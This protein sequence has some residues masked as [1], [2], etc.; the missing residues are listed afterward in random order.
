VRK[1]RLRCL[2]HPLEYRQGCAGRMQWEADRL[3]DEA[4]RR[5]A[6][7]A[8]QAAA[9]AEVAR[10]VRAARDECDRRGGGLSTKGVKGAQE[11]C[12]PEQR[13]ALTGRLSRLS[14]WMSAARAWRE[15]W[16]E[17]GSLRCL[18]ER[19]NTTVAALVAKSLEQ[20]PVE[21]P[22]SR[23]ETGNGEGKEEEER[24]TEGAIG[25]VALDPA[26]AGPRLRRL[27]QVCSA[28]RGPAVSKQSGAEDLAGCLCS[29]AE[30]E[31]KLLLRAEVL[32][33]RSAAA[34]DAQASAS[35]QAQ[36]EAERTR[37][38]A[39]TAAEL[40]AKS[41]VFEYLRS[42]GKL[43]DVLRD[44]MAGTHGEGTAAAA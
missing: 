29:E 43:D 11:V 39:A 28:L 26:V 34:R 1:E 37:A 38:A 44:A 22:G 10:E 17:R 33:R 4:A 21:E 6:A 8:G 2:S 18:W 23:S 30:A 40:K 5:R 3:V 25:N 16:T 42:R 32:A 19:R 14:A 24:D 7:V 36:A 15:E 31:R 20:P 35:S 12:G 13:A 41:A 9:A 27:L